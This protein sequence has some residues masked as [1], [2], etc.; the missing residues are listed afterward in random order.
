MRVRIDNGVKL[1]TR[2]RL[3]TGMLGKAKR[4]EK[5][6]SRFVGVG[7]NNDRPKSSQ[8][9]VGS[10]SLSPPDTRLQTHHETSG[11]NL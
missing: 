1:G 4:G 6:V 9:Q 7:V 10:S 2:N 5:E 3:W 11:H 8:S